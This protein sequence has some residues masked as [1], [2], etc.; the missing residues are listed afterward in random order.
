MS[1][2]RRSSWL[3]HSLRRQF[4]FAVSALTLLILAGGMVAV[5]A[6]RTTATTIRE[7]TEERLVRM[8]V[9][10]DLVQRTLLIEGASHQLAEAT[11]LNEM[12]EYYGEVVKLLGEFDS[13]VD[14]L[15]SEM[16]GSALLNL[17]QASQM[18]RNS[19]NVTAQL[20]E[21]RLQTGDTGVPPVVDNSPSADRY[22]QELHTQAKALL[23]S[24]RLQS[25]YFTRRYRDAMLQ[26]DD[27]TRRNTRWIMILMA[28]SLVL[29]W[30][31]A[32]WFLGHHV[33]GRLL[34]VSRSLRLG[35]DGAGPAAREAAEPAAPACDEIDEMAHAVELFWNDRHQLEQRTEELRLARDEAEAA[36]K[37]KSVFLANMS[38]ELRTPLNAILGF[39][40][41]MRE[42]PGLNPAQYDNLDIINRSGEHLLKLINDVLEIAKIEAG[43]L[44]LETTSFDLYD[45]VR[46]VADMMRLRAQQKGLQLLLEQSPAIPRYIR[47]DEARLRQIMVN[48][49]GNAVKFTDHGSVTIR[50]DVRENATRHLRIE[51]EDTGPGIGETDLRQLFKPFTQLPKGKARGGTGLGLSIVHQ[52]VKLMDGTIVVES[53]LGKGSLFR[54]ELPLTSAGKEEL[55]PPIREK[56]A[57][58]VGLVPGQPHYRILIAEDQRDNQV[59]LARLMLNLGL[60][61]KLADNGAA[62]VKTFQEWQPHLIWMDWR[63]PE[64]DGTEAARRIRQLPGGNDVKIV[65]VTASAFLEE[66]TK[67]LSAGMDGVI[68]KPYRFNDIYDTLAQ[69]LELKFTYAKHVNEE[70]ESSPALTP[71]ML[72][73]IDE[74]LL[75]SLHGALN[76]LNN[77]DIASVIRQI[78]EK[79]MTLAK[80]LKSLADNF[81]YPTILQALDQQNKCSRVK[82]NGDTR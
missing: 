22:Y 60:D 81:D 33:L 27:V 44:Q 64:M 47:G 62:C 82:N 7:L 1:R 66:H 10:Q 2:L 24:A 38:H 29:A 25:D 63:M 69:Q 28:G 65:A 48:L 35:N 32:Q 26:L 50:L 36:N 43:K 79:D 74:K 52:F 73:G 11:S 23:N 67:V 55:P 8:Q 72:E 16:G 68:R 15:A 6:M 53:R 17:H 51:I 80:I 3:P 37:A 49:V 45:L 57:D 20:L 78:G 70:F 12:H 13:L 61:V 9:A 18:F 56:F 76:T 71:S 75:S 30:V 54:V 77:E 41:L 34:Q 59:L 5:Y 58:V 21:R 42:E 4:L 40:Q 31:V 19:A 39:S 14:A 46:E